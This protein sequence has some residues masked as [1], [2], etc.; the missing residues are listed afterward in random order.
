MEIHKAL[1]YNQ[2]VG[3]YKVLSSNA[4]VGSIVTTK[5]GFFVMPKSVSYWGFIKAVNTQIESFGKKEPAEISKSAGVDIINDPRFVEFLKE[6]QGIINLEYL[7]DV[8]HLSLSDWNYPQQK[9]HPL[10]KRHKEAMDNELSSD[11]FVIPA[12][13]FPRWFYSRKEKY[14][15]PLEE[16]ENLWKQKTRDNSLQYFAPPRDPYTKTYRKFKDNNQQMDIYD[17][18]VQI[19]IL[20][21]CKNGHISDIPWYQLFCAGIDG[22]KQAMKNPNG[23]EL[24][25]YQCQDCERGGRHELQWIENRNN[26][27][28]WGTLKCKK[29][30]K[31]YGLEGIMNIHPFCKGE[32][33]WNGIGSKSNESCKDIN[34]GKG[35]MQMAL[36]TSNSIYYA[37]S[38]GSLYIP[39]QYMNN[40]ILPRDMQKVLDLLNNKWFPKA[41]NKTPDL[42]KQAYITEVDLVENADNAGITIKQEEAETIKKRFLQVKETPKDPHEA[43]RYD[44]Y[45]VFSGNTCSLPDVSG[46]EFRDID[47]PSDLKPFFRKIQ[48]VDTMAMT[49]TQL[50]FSRVSMPITL[51][52]EGSVVRNEGQKIY[53]EPVEKVYSLP[54]NQSFGEGIFFEFNREA[55]QRWAES[56]EDLFAIRYD[57]PEGEIGKALK[58][59]MKQYGAPQFYLLHTFSHIIL[60]ELEF[61]CGYPTASLQERLYYSDR[62]CGVLLYTADGSEGSMGGL[63]WQ[64][65]PRLISRIIKA[66]LNNARDCSSD[67]L[68]WE[69]E[70]QLNLAACFSCCLVSETSCEKRNL[71]L[72]RRALVD[73]NFGFFKSLDCSEN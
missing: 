64:G 49:L 63:V 62:M 11:H 2:G 20:L 37:D 44:E 21:I 14:F 59:E 34:G 30:G 25:D 70:D 24:F 38:F 27:E 39:P 43:Y 48:Q 1:Q 57:Q 69:N 32:M 42:T 8:P 60:K 9:E 68:C 72:D 18:L 31:T 50:R 67:P 6:D 55:I 26:S 58:D 16:W 51:R 13:H 17:T 15:K 61:S 10:F 41:L 23:F 46:L 66:A 33:P 73:E 54:A 5:A 7:I 35:V 47:L 36:V 28:S 29:C 52:I 19:P 56:H 65:Q 12:I 71:G 40:T 3:K 53:N 4:G 22:K 45:K